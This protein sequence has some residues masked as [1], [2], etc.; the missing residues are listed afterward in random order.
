LWKDRRPSYKY[1]KVWGCHEKIV[2]PDPKKV[3]TWL[4]TI[5]CVFIRYVYNN[6]AYQ[7]LVHKLNI[8]NIH[9]NT[10]NECYII[11]RCI[12]IKRSIRKLLT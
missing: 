3:K 6:N 7:F 12:S 2:V 4:K 5:K 9:H 8:K 11:W 1:L 10:I